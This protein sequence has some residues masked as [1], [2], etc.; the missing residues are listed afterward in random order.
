MSDRAK[1]GVK[2]VLRVHLV[3]R[4]YLFQRIYLDAHVLSVCLCIFSTYAR[5]SID[6]ARYERIMHH[7]M[8]IKP[9]GKEL[10]LVSLDTYASAAT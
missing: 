5:V 3:E 1:S 7:L 9:Y 6:L 2:E 4:D 10:E 8:Y